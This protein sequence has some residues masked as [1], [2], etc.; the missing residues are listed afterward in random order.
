[1]KELY[2]RFGEIPKN[3]K[4]VNFL[5]MSFSKNE[6]FSF[7]LDCN[8]YEEALNCLDEKHFESG[9]SVFKK[10]VDGLPLLENLM[11]ITSLLARIGSKI[12]EVEAMEIEKGNDN[13]PLIRNIRVIKQRRINKEKLLEKI[14]AKLIQN[15]KNVKKVNSNSQAEND[16]VQIYPFYREDYMNI[17]TG[18][19]KS[20]VELM[21]TNKNGW[22]KMPPY[23]EF[24]YL[25]GVFSCPVDSFDTRLG[26]K[27][28]EKD[29]V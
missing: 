11:Q 8:E 28:T 13:E 7:F 4:S 3:E 10:D 25:N 6:D 14:L 22:I 21:N 1:M 20:W 5:K 17:K 2:L 12:Y 9:V 26:I 15:F 19:R 18:E 23:M 29:E 24:H 16:A 27:R